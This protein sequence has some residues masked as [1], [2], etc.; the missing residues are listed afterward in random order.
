M[1]IDLKQP[2][3]AGDKVPLVLSVQPGGAAAGNSLSTVKL[4]LEVRGGAAPEPHRH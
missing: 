3:K 4:E 1:L 2:L